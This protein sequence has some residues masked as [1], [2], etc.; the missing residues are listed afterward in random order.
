MSKMRPLA[1]IDDT[2][3]AH[4]EL[5]GSLDDP[6]GRELLE[7]YAKAALAIDEIQ[8]VA[9]PYD[10][11][12]HDIQ[13][14]MRAAIES[15]LKHQDFN[16]CINTAPNA[17]PILT[18]SL[19]FREPL[20][21]KNL[22]QVV[23]TRLPETATPEERQ[24]TLEDAAIEMCEDTWLTHTQARGKARFRVV[25]GGAGLPTSKTGCFSL[26]AFAALVSTAGWKLT[27]WLT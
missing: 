13:L 9:A 16:P 22:L 3:R 2:M 26:L 27:H 8:A 17:L 12:Q 23:H 25:E 20:R 10:L 19:L 4:L 14:M 1:R 24:E 5:G 18:V 7:K 15:V 11:T 6:V 21:L